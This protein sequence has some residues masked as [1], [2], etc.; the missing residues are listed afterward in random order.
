MLIQHVERYV[1]YRHKLGVGF[2]EG[3]HTL[4]LFARYADDR[5]DSHVTIDRIH[6][7]CSQSC[8]PQRARTKYNLLR[9]FSMFL[10]AEDPGHAA[11]P[12]GA[13]GCRRRP[14]PSPHL[15]HPEQI[16][17]IMSAAL[18]LPNSTI[19]PYTYHCLFG[20]L[21][22]TGMRVSEALGLR[23][24]DLTHDGLLVRRSKGGGSR[25]L[26]IHPTTR[27]AVEAYLNRRNRAFS[28]S[29]DLFIVSTGRAPDRSTVRKVFVDLA[30][31][32]GIRGPIGTPGPRL[33]DLRHSFA[34]RSLEACVHDYDAVRR[35]MTALRDYLGHSSILHTYWYLEATPVLMRTIAT[36]NEH[37]FVGG[38]R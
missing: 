13:F 7:W 9:R 14:R 26:P 6:E 22:V 20:L 2:G 21:A 10:R 3:E 34:V 1:D 32:L 38:G 12:T 16:A 11:P 35:H 30:R 17:A 37:R 15:L 27:E 29:D 18:S 5:G 28:V 36:A 23:R 24:S 31:Q 19:K 8:T 25:L 4:T 33:H